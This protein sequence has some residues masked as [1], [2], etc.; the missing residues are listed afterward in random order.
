MLYTCEN[1]TKSHTCRGPL[2]KVTDN[3]KKRVLCAATI[4]KFILTGHKI[5]IHENV[6]RKFKPEDKKKF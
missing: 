2:Y 3:S 4:S 1:H 5:E 6:P